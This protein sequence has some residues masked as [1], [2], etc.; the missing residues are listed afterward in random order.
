MVGVVLSMFG[1]GLIL[2]RLPLSIA[3]DEFGIHQKLILIGFLL[4]GVGAFVMGSANSAPYLIA[5]R[6]ISGISCS[7]WVLIIV[8]FN[9]FFPSGGGIKSTTMLITIT[10]C[11]KIISASLTG[12]LN[13]LGGY[14]LAYYVAAVLAVLAFISFWS[15]KPPKVNIRS[16]FKMKETL[17]AFFTPL[18]ILPT[19]MDL[20]S[21]FAFN[22]GPSSFMP[23]LADRLGATNIQLSLLTVV[24]EAV[25]LM[26]SLIIYTLLRRIGQVRLIMVSIMLTTLGMLGTAFASSLWHIYLGQFIITSGA[27]I[28]Y[29]IMLGLVIDTVDYNKRSTMVGIQ[30]SV[31]AL[32]IL[33]GPMIGGIVADSL[34]IRSTFILVAIFVFVC[35][36]L[37]LS[38]YAHYR[39]IHNL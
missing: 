10:C 23:I 25:S 13:N 19:L 35:G 20:V 7:I 16:H 9:N 1:L 36:T 31:T 33:F 3:A 24:S 11:G 14:R 5:G 21:T 28:S 27:G 8:E 34:G 6:I 29:P 2:F 17:P 12:V 15:I 30:Q 18:V 37:L 4:S 32:G 26:L 38:R 22:I 39:R